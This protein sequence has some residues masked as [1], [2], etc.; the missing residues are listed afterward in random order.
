[1][2]RLIQ[3]DIITHV[4]NILPSIELAR[5]ENNAGDDAGD[6]ARLLHILKVIEDNM[7][8][9]SARLLRQ[10]PLKAITRYLK[11]KECN[12]GMTFDYIERLILSMECSFTQEPPAAKDD[13]GGPEAPDPDDF[14]TTIHVIENTRKRT[15]RL[16]VDGELSQDGV[17]RVLSCFMGGG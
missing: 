4:T 2:Q 1:M 5:Q 9:P 15:F 13:E 12:L 14:K 7:Q 6:G 8:P 16:F 17:K 3:E 10:L 11:E